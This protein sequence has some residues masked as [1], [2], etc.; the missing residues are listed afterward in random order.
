MNIVDDTIDFETY[1]KMTEA[2]T[3]VK[4]AKSYRSLVKKSMRSHSDK[5]K[6]FLPWEKTVENFNFR[7]GE[8]T[9]WAGQNG[10]GKSTIVNHVTLALLGQ[11]QK[12]CIASP[13]MT[14]Q[15]VIKHMLRMYSGM[16][17]ASA[18][19]RDSEEALKNFDEILDEM[20][21]WTD[22][23]LWL[24][25]QVGMVNS[26]AILGMARYAANEL[27]V[28]HVFIDNL[29]KVVRGEDDYNAQKDFVSDLF[30]AARDTG[31][32]IHLIHHIKK[33]PKESDVPDKNNVK[34]TGAITDI[35]DNL[36]MVWRNKPKEDDIKMNGSTAKSWEDPDVL[37]LCRKQREYEGNE[38]GEPTIRLWYDRESQQYLPFKGAKL[39]QFYRN[40]P[41]REL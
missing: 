25:D 32:H 20:L 26:E 34:G 30:A 40:Y 7:P 11:E 35:V 31:V 15:N 37:L 23:R 6:I 39:Q 41:F 13:E 16:N 8:L 2:K 29:S 1:L 33:L 27:K 14:P 28:Q 21:D 36:F 17:P 19:Y 24:Y 3:L 5:A 12:V 18:E 38:E 4:P 9:V 10:H 22:K